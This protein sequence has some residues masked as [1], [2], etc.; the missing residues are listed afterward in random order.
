MVQIYK[1]CIVDL[2]RGEDDPILALQLQYDDEV[3]C[4]RNVH[5]QEVVDFCYN[6]GDQ[7]LV[8]I[9]N[10]GLDNRLMR[11]TVANQASSRSHLLFAL[12]FTH[13]HGDGTI[14]KGKIVFV[15]LAGSERMAMLGYSLYLYEEAL[16]INES[17]A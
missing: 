8:A 12:T 10:K 3:A 13:T 14:I 6:D 9:L 11:S 5:H 17:L 1:S 16:F 2:L 7:R 15:D 4:V